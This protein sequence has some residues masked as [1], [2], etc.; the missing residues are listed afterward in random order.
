MKANCSPPLAAMTGKYGRLLGWASLLL[1]F[2]GPFDA[3]LAAYGK[4]PNSVVDTSVIRINEQKFLGTSLARDYVMV[5]EQG[6]EFTLGDMLGKPLVLVLSYY[7]CDG[8]CPSLNNAL[9]SS[10]GK[11]KSWKL[12][13]DYR[14]LTVS[15]D[16][17]DTVKN[18]QMF[19]HHAGFAKGLPEGWKMAVMKNPAEIQSM[20]SSVGYKYFWEPRDRVFLHSAAFVVISP[21]GRVTR[22]LYAA[23]TDAN[24][25]AVSI[26]KAY[27]NQ[28]SA[29]NAIEFVVGACYS[30]N[31]QE[32]KYTLNY[33]IVIA[34]GAL[35]FGGTALASGFVLM[36]GRVKS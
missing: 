11:M 12:G 5:D 13:E 25:L 28:I 9:K 1:A 15:F 34:L 14:V 33:P 27:G 16:Q 7:S 19:I 2:A 35:G 32:G 3:A 6:Q 23:S 4:T 26:T 21:E 20:A 17:K 24:D 8:A 18:T 30:Y 22:Y 31:Y 29:A 36:R 10:L